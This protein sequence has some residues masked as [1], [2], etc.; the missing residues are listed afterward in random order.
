MLFEGAGFFVRTGGAY[1]PL[2][3]GSGLNCYTLSAA[4]SGAPTGA[5]IGGDC[6]GAPLNAIKYKS[7]SYGG[8]SVSADYGEDDFWDVGGRYA[9]EWSGFKVAAA[10]GY[11]EATDQ[12]PFVAGVGN[13][14]N[15]K[16]TQ[17]QVG[18]Y[19][20]HLASGLF[21]HG[22]CLREDLSGFVGASAGLKN[23]NPEHW[24]VKG[25]IRAKCL[26]YGATIAYGEYSEGNDQIGFAA[27]SNGA[28]VIDS[29]VRWWGVGVVQEIDAA[30][31]SIWVKYR[32]VDGEYTSNTELNGL[33]VGK[34]DLESLQMVTFGAMINF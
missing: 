4:A 24:Y 21:L 25:G 31:M 26:P 5:G 27:Y 13:Y 12:N 9:G 17:I 16:Y 30:A 1:T 18:G 28:G 32:N 14:N 8:F 19:I 7:P 6:T 34:N 3:W 10:I 22:A 23:L 2:T 11:S 29:N 33:A 20:Q 15:A